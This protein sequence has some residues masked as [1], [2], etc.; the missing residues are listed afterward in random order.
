[1]AR[2]AEYKLQADIV[3]YVRMVAP[4]GLC[5][6]YPSGGLRSKREAALLKWIGVIPGVPDLI[7]VY[8]QS[9]FGIH[10]AEVKTPAGRLSPDQK[11]F[12]AWADKHGVPCAVWRSIDDAHESLAAWQIKTREAA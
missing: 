9:P 3:A 7:L 8:P 1:M 12:L 5:F 4:D 6:H 11:A 2:N 10:F